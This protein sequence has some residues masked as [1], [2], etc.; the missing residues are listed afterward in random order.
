MRLD[1]GELTGDNV[2]WMELAGHDSEALADAWRRVHYACQAAAE[3]GKAFAEPGD[4][5]SHTCLTWF[6]GAKFLDGFFAG[7]EVGTSKRVR[8]ALRVWDMR[9]FVIGES[10]DAIGELELEGHTIEQATG[11]IVD[12]ALNILDEP[13]RQATEPETGLPAHAIGT[14]AVFGPP[15]QFPQAEL[16]RLYSDANS[17]LSAASAQIDGAGA[18]RTRPG[19]FDISTVVKVGSGS[20]RLGLSPP[21]D[22]SAHGYWYVSGAQSDRPKLSFGCWHEVAADAPADAVFD[23]V[24]L[25]GVEDVAEQRHRVGTFL[26]EAFNAGAER[27]ADA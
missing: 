23:L 27:H 14:G 18:V 25:H 24:D 16:I 12:S 6:D 9:L 5:D 13:I 8:G 11:W 3:V 19:R 22:V 1:A 26:S 21:D 7:P 10:G 15:D 20:I 17:I 4:D 2:K